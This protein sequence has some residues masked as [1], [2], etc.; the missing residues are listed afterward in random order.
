MAEFPPEVTVTAVPPGSADGCAV[1]AAYFRDI[2][3]RYHGRPATADEVAAAMAA[4]PSDDLSPPGGLLLVAR[5]AGTVMGCAGLRLLPAGIGEV[6]RVFVAPEARRRGVGVLLM[7]AVEAAAREH[8]LS[9]LRLDTGSH[10]TEAQQLYARIGYRE[11]PA[12]NDGRFSDR[13]YEKSLT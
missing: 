10:L 9:T 3:A 4:E 12:F 6:T 5:Q 11:V 13:W 8:G 1:L 2:V 7:G